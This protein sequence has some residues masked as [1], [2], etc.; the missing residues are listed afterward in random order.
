[1]SLPPSPPTFPPP[2]PPPP[3]PPALLWYLLHS[4]RK[5]RIPEFYSVQSCAHGSLRTKSQTR[6]FVV[7]SCAE[8]P[9]QGGCCSPAASLVASRAPPAAGRGR[10]PAP[11]QSVCQG[12]GHPAALLLAQPVSAAAGHVLPGTQGPATG[13]TPEGNSEMYSLN[14]SDNACSHCLGSVC[15]LCFREHSFCIQSSALDGNAA[16][17]TAT[18][19]QSD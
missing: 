17:S 5:K 7:Q 4:N 9:E 2:P 18:N 19:N 14:L 12:A 11:A 1:M 15:D 8:H 6:L 10:G 3:F 13:H 16:D